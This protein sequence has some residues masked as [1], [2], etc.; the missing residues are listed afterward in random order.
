MTKISI[1]PVGESRNVYLFYE[2]LTLHLFYDHC[3]PINGSMIGAQQVFIMTELKAS[4]VCLARCSLKHCRGRL[5]IHSLNLARCCLYMI[6]S[7]ECMGLY[8]AQYNL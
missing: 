3:S 7:A 8:A 2:L 1:G 6:I 4:I 5:K